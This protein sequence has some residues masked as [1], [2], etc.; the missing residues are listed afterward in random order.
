MTYICARMT[1]KKIF[2][3]I[4]VLALLYGV[5][6]ISWYYAQ[7]KLLLHPEAVDRNTR[8]D[9]GQPFTEVNLNFDKETNINIIQFKAVDSASPAPA[10]PATAPGPSDHNPTQ[11]PAQGAPQGITPRD[12]AAKGVVLYFHGNKKNIGWY[13][14]YAAGFTHKGY[15]V[16]MLDYPGYGK[17]T[18]K[19]TEQKVYD[20]A[21]LL[22]KLAR[23]RWRP[24]QITIYG[25]S[26]GTGIAAQLASVRDC[27]RLI[28]ECPYYS[29]LSVFRHYLPVY[30]VS[31]MLHYHFPTNEYLPSVTAPITIF[32]GTDDGLIPYGNAARLQPLLKTGDEFITIE[33]GSHNDLHDFPLFRQKLDSVLAR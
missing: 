32:H 9:F 18:G 16:W 13:A 10:S 2:R 20:N 5:I 6:G 17:S 7:D 11:A 4:K 22:Y 3:W 23:S 25:K 28:L 24:D 21:L 12:S 27:R 30:P 1:K 19:F 31:T 33:G 8:Y 29:M 26:L 15:E 14:H